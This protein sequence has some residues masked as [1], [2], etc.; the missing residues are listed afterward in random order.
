MAIEK[1]TIITVRETKSLADR[2]AGRGLSKLS[3]DTPEQQCDLM[4]AA[5]AMR[6]MARHLNDCDVLY[7]DGARR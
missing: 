5:K 6:A 1:P 2:L 4:L 7:L 3:R